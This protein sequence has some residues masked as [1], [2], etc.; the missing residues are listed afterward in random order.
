MVA[1]SKERSGR[2]E[3]RGKVISSLKRVPGFASSFRAHQPLSHVVTHGP[4]R[5]QEHKAREDRCSGKVRGNVV[6]HEPASDLCDHHLAT[7]MP[8]AIASALSLDSLG[9]NEFPDEE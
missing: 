4:K 9:S 5:L 8:D 7:G 2:R 6:T 1:Q 3:K